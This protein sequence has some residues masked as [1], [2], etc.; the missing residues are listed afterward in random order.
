MY[1][2]ELERVVGEIKRRGARRVLLQLPDGM[3]PFAFQMAEYIRE[4]TPTE[5]IISG[6]SCYGAC[7]IASRQAIE[8]NVDLY[9]G[10]NHHSLNRSCIQA[11][12]F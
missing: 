9:T 5:V 12:C 3:R 1:E 10:R 6:D 8:L 11:V 4:A 2:L 7:D